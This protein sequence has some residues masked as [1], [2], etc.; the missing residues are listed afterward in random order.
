MLS[1]LKTLSVA[2]IW[3]K[4]SSSLPKIYLCYL[5]WREITESFWYCVIYR[6]AFCGGYL[7]S[8]IKLGV[9]FNRR[10]AGSINYPGHQLRNHIEW[11]HQRNQ[12]ARPEH[13]R[14]ADVTTRNIV[15]WR[16]FNCDNCL[17]VLSR[18]F[19][20]CGKIILLSFSRSVGCLDVEVIF[21]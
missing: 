1:V 20:K 2:A 7:R 10:S 18:K 6:P 14:R 4:K 13:H 5:S 17:S 3:L 19:P 9:H 15:R 11:R 12:C 16:N 21:Y 8:S